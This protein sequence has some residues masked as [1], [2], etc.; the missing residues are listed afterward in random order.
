METKI[1]LNETMDYLKAMLFRLPAGF[2]HY[3]ISFEVDGQE[4][5]TT[6]TNLEAINAA[7]NEEYEFDGQYTLR[8][9]SKDEAREDLV[10]EI[11]EDNNIELVNS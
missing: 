4:Y 10:N 2:G 6:T 11:L 5:Y 9:S 8:Y 3:K 1:K 7:F